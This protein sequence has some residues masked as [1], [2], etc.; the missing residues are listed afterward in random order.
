MVCFFKHEPTSEHHKLCGGATRRFSSKNWILNIL[1]QPLRVGGVRPRSQHIVTAVGQRSS[2]EVCVEV[3]QEVSG[4]FSALRCLGATLNHKD[5]GMTSNT[6]LN[7]FSPSVFLVLLLIFT[8]T[9]ILSECYDLKC[10]TDLKQVGILMC[11]IRKLM[12]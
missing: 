3:R 5:E 7:H 8:N 12:F 6:S 1:C 2:L 10:V 4:I 11:K 9:F